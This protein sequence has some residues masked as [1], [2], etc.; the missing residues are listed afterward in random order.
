MVRMP[1]VTSVPLKI[2]GSEPIY[3]GLELNDYFESLLLL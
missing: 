1:V 2:D 3:S